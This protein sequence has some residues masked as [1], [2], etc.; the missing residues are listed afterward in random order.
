MPPKNDG[1]R[2]QVW[3]RVPV[4]KRWN[5]L[6]TSLSK[7][8]NELATFLMNYYLSN[9]PTPCDD[10][11]DIPPRLTPIEIP[12]ANHP[13]TPEGLRNSDIQQF[14]PNAFASTP[15]TAIPSFSP[16]TA[17]RNVLQVH[18]IALTH[19]SLQLVETIP[20]TRLPNNININFLIGFPV[21]PLVL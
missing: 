18:I 17:I 4:Y 16:P 8:H 11:M 12:L 20:I 21:T 13:C 14:N 7:S 2:S 3:F 10:P 6:R 19:H 9:D 15:S 1:G 5:E